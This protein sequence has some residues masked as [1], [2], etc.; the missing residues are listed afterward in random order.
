MNVFA[1]P[2][3]GHRSND[4]F[5]LC[6]CSFLSLLLFARCAFAINNVSF[7]HA[8]TFCSGELGE[9]QSSVRCVTGG[10]VEDTRSLHLN[11]THLIRAAADVAPQRERA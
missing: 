11:S 2:D 1:L 7:I 4:T 9:F 6:S 5:I 8:L 3:E 10:C